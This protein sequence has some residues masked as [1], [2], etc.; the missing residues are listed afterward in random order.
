MHRASDLV[1]DHL[2]RSLALRLS[3]G[4]Q[5]R[6][7]LRHDF[8]DDLLRGGV[9]IA[10][11]QATRHADFT[12]T[13]QLRGQPDKLRSKGDDG[14]VIDAGRF[15]GRQIWSSIQTSKRNVSRGCP[16][17]DTNSRADSVRKPR[18]RT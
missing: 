1:Q 18:S 10:A 3:A 16:E 7:F 11:A 15:L 5:H 6:N 9:Q 4:L 2:Q 13:H 12:T 8:R 17:R 14:E